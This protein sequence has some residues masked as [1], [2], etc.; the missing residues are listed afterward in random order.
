MA[1]PK[2]KISRSRRDKRQ[3]KLESI[4][5]GSNRMFQLSSTQNAHRACPNCGYYKVVQYFYKRIIGSP[6]SAK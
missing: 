2:H 4:C 5:T 6:I 3:S 1:L